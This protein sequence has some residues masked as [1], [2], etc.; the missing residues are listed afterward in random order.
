MRDQ[1]LSGSLSTK[2]YPGKLQFT[3]LAWYAREMK[4]D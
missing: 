2:D 4:A 3:W 1:I